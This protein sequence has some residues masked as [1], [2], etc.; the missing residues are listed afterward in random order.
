MLAISIKS[1]KKWQIE[2]YHKSIKQNAS[3]EKSSTKVIRS[4]KNPI[5]ASIIAYCK[6]KCFDLKLHLVISR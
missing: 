2:R 3:L 6:L 5:F 4:Q 1:K